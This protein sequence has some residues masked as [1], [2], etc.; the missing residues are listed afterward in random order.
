MNGMLGTVNTYR[1]NYGGGYAG[2]RLAN[3][4]SNVTTRNLIARECGRE[5][6][7]L[8][9]S[10]NIRLNNAQI[11]NC[12]GSGIWLENVV[13]CAVLSGCTND[14]VSVSGSGSYAN[15]TMNCPG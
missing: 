1:C 10:N 15:V 4:C 11:H 14:G 2:L 7:V 9:G 3:N 6:F 12:S 13:N 8:T 5:Y